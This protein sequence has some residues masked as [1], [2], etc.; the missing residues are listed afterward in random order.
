MIKGSRLIKSFSHAFRGIQVVFK[1]EQSFRLQVF[2]GV[3]VFLCALWFQ[4]RTY[5]FILIL[6]L[7]GAVL[8][9]ELINS[10]FERIVDA[11]KPRIH[12]AVKDMKDIMAATV[13]L[14]SVI[15]AIIGIVIFL[16]H[17]IALFS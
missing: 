1:T 15:A 3:I 11:F 14:M 6:L 8:V 12:P 9:L 7:I 13:F 17:F 5:E 4:L 10:V 2:M 16:P